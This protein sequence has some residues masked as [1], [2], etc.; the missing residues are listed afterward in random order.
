M[1]QQKQEAVNSDLANRKSLAFPLAVARRGNQEIVDEIGVSQH[2][3]SRQRNRDE[4][5][6][7]VLEET[8][9]SFRQAQLTAL[10]KVVDKAFTGW[11]IKTQKQ[12]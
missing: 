7:K 6:M 1:S 12:E 9:A 3:L 5:L 8:K 4:H 2:T 11:T 10:S